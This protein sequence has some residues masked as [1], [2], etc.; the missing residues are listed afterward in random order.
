MP[1]LTFKENKML[2]DYI[3]FKFFD[4]VFIN[5]TYHYCEHNIA[6]PGMIRVMITLHRESTRIVS[7]SIIFM[8]INYL[9]SLADFQTIL[10]KILECLEATR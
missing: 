6:K 10:V 8:Y 3:F 5:L 1:Q 9:K 2:Q 4:I 7:V